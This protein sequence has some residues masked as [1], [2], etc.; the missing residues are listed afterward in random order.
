[1]SQERERENGY[2]NEENKLLSLTKKKMLTRSQ[3]DLR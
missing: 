2:E 1:M 3:A